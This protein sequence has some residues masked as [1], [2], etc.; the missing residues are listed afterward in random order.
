MRPI[1]KCICGGHVLLAMTL[2][3]VATLGPAAAYAVTFEEAAEAF[4]Y[5]YGSTGTIDVSLMFIDDLAGVNNYTA[6]E[7]I[8]ASHNLIAGIDT[9]QFSGLGN[10]QSPDLGYNQIAS[11]ESG[12]FSGLT[13]LQE[14]YLNYNQISSI[15]SGDFS[16]LTNLQYFWLHQNQITSIES[17]AFSGLTNL[18]RLYLNSNQIS[19]IESGAFSGLGNLELLYMYDNALTRLNLSGAE[20]MDLEYFRVM[21]GNTITSVDLALASLSDLAFRTLMDEFDNGY[22]FTLDL[23]GADLSA[24]AN[25]SPMH[26]LDDLETLDMPFAELIDVDQVNDLVAALEPWALDNL[27]L[28]SN[29][30]ELMDSTTQTALTDWDAMPDNTL[31]ILELILGDTDYDCD[32]DFAD[33][34]NLANN[35]TGSLDPGMGGKDWRQGDFDGDGDG[36]FKD[37][38]DLANHY[39]GP[40]DGKAVPEPST[41]TLLAI[42]TLAITVGWCRR[43]RAG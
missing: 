33:F 30:W 8:W 42:G 26:G 3:A 14:L 23:R 37:F 35:Y 28:S 39:T 38:N 5:T 19:S 41:L 18:Q 13:N 29:Q 36:D 21:S 31:T 2:V 9:N 40:L 32:I 11:I 43:K 6:A 24:V 25:L 12:D 15:E 20:F 16:G 22:I 27:T 7:A 10:L 17:G 1:T 4:G 34:N